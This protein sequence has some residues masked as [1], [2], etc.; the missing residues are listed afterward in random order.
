MVVRNVKQND[1]I[2]CA[3]IENRLGERKFRMCYHIWNDGKRWFFFL[4]KNFFYFVFFVEQVELIW[5]LFIRKL[6]K[7]RRTNKKKWFKMQ[8]IKFCAVLKARSERVNVCM[9]C[10][11]VGIASESHTQKMS[12]VQHFLCERREW[13]FRYYCWFCCL[14]PVLVSFQSVHSVLI[15]VYS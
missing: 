3:N 10:W 5:N 9:L 8:R 6:F 2:K 12:S 4:F 14:Y 15:Y 13:W 1:T 7:T 11:I